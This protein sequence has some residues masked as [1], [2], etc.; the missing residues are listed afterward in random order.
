MAQP[1]FFLCTHDSC[2]IYWL[3]CSQR[4]L[5]I[6]A[7][8]SQTLEVTDPLEGDQLYRPPPPHFTSW[9]SSAKAANW[10]GG[11]R[12]TSPSCATQAETLPVE[13]RHH[14][15]PSSPSLS[16]TFAAQSNTIHYCSSRAT[17]KVQR[18]RKEELCDSDKA[19][20]IAAKIWP[21]LRSSSRTHI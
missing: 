17:F 11:C 16:T 4:C 19:E 14:R 7:V 10:S 13:T 8:S 2:F 15:D 9:Q 6:S 1:W 12:T 3:G 21:Y 5:S 18:E 20:S